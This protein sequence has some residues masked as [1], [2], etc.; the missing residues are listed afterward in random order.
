MKASAFYCLSSMGRYEKAVNQQRATAIWREPGQDDRM[1]GRSNRDGRHD[2]AE[3]SSLRKGPR[4]KQK[5]SRDVGWMDRVQ[6]QKPLTKTRECEGGA[7]GGFDLAAA[8]AAR[9]PGLS[10]EPGED[11]KRVKEKK[12]P[13]PAPCVPQPRSEVMEVKKKPLAAMRIVLQKRREA[14]APDLSEVPGRSALEK[15]QARAG[16]KRSWASVVKGTDQ[17]NRTSLENI[18][19][20]TKGESCEGKVH[21]QERQEMKRENTEEEEEEEDTRGDQLE[22]NQPELV[23]K[24]KIS[25]MEASNEDL[26]KKK[27][28]YK[29]QI[30]QLRAEVNSFQTK[31]ESVEAKVHHHPQGREQDQEPERDHQRIQQLEERAAEVGQKLAASHREIQQL[32]DTNQELSRN[33]ERSV[34]RWDQ[35][36]QQLNHLTEERLEVETRLQQLR[37][38]TR[39]LRHLCEQLVQKKQK[40][41]LLALFKKIKKNFRKSSKKKKEDGP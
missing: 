30:Q 14:P 32:E 26:L 18:K 13:R 23:R 27:D 21:Q 40:G 25:E 17:D 10:G 3:D 8:A 11:L 24:K 5:S 29:K 12:K 28:E 15:R 33:V 4:A 31:V 6:N 2:D 16:P 9:P 34:Q 38:E 39:D 7:D 1:T 35:L 37:E 19:E 20:A 36:V 41:G 22:D